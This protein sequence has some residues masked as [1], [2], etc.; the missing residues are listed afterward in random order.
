MEMT[1]LFSLKISE[2]DQDRLKSNF[3]TKE[4][5]FC[6]NMDEA[7]KHIEQ[8]EVIVTYG[9]DLNEELV[10][11]AKNLQWV[12]VLSAGL[13]K[14][15]FRALE[16][17]NVL[18]TNVRG[19]HKV[20]MA[21][22]AISMLLQV[23]RQEKHLLEKE[24]E[25]DWNRDNK[26]QEITGKTMLIAGTGAIGQEVARLAQAFRMRTI[27]VS[28]SGRTVEYFN[29]N[30]T[31]DEMKSYLPKA[32]FVVSVLPST[33]ETKHLFTIDYFQ[34]MNENAIFLNMGRGDVVEG[35]VILKAIREKEIMHAVL[36]VFETEP[37]PEDNPLW[38]EANITV[39]PHLSGISPN[40]LPRALKIFEKN[41]DIFVNDQSDYINKID[42]KRGY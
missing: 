40:Y 27:G 35:D 37:L 8:A 14:M 30:V 42:T 1:I 18:V 2:T 7:K 31:T 12:S 26:P 24:K 34:A 19:I 29:E 3:P 28:R 33:N 17:K 16:K 38:D 11:R 39:T 41:L 13:D 23:Y 15:P 32:D 10:E 4:F 36:D 21:E 5:V 25:H 6:K 20:P 22:Y 9:T